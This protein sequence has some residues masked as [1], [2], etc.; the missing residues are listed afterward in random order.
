[1]IPQIRL[2]QIIWPVIIIQHWINTYVGEPSYQTHKSTKLLNR[3]L[4][5]LSCHIIYIDR[6]SCYT[7]QI[8]QLSCEKYKYRSTKLSNNTHIGHLSC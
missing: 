6:L 7:I 5:R 4:N 2:L 3:Y 8:S 1:M